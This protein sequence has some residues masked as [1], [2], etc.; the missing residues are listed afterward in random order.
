MDLFLDD[1][2]Y[3]AHS[4]AADA[5]WAGV[6]VLTTPGTQFASRVAASLTTAAGLP[7]LVVPSL[8]AYRETAIA[9]GLGRRDIEAVKARLTRARDGDPP[10]FGIARFVRALEAG[11]VGVMDRAV[12]GQRP[13]DIDIIPTTFGDGWTH[14]ARDNKASTA[15]AAA[16]R[17]QVGQAGERWLQTESD[18]PP[19]PKRRRIRIEL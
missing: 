9:F 14:V 1:L 15:S 6:P 17:G 11:L 12:R 16:L 10:L 18:S 7:D 19:P 8:D 4:T 3:N 2:D 5:L 13:A